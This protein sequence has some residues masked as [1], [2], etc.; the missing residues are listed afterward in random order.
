M[1]MP[2]GYRI[3]PTRLSDALFSRFQWYRRL[4][5]GMWWYSNFTDT[6]WNMVPESD[7]IIEDYRC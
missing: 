7:E 2:K 5:G 3:G 1:A 4:R 6:W